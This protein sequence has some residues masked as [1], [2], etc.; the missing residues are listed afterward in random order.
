[1]HMLTL[2]KSLTMNKIHFIT[3]ESSHGTGSYLQ[4]RYDWSSLPT[5][6]AE[7]AQ[8]LDCSRS[9]K[10][11]SHCRPPGGDS[12]LEIALIKGKYCG[13]K[14]VNHRTIKLATTTQAKIRGSPRD[15]VLFSLA[16]FL[17]PKMSDEINQ[18]FT[19]SHCY[20]TSPHISLCMLP[21]TGQSSL[22]VVVRRSCLSSN[23]RE[24]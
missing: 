20:L 18:W 12:Y 22:W 7:M 4:M 24:A 10:L 15:H 14:F 19:V 8:N 23:H 21:L 2:V 3:P 16:P 11:V 1:M 9:T 5:M 6:G 13:Q 17:R